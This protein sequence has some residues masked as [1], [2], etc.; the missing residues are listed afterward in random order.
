MG[1]MGFLSCI[2]LMLSGD[3]LFTVNSF[4]A[5][6]GKELKRGSKFLFCSFQYMDGWERAQ[7]GSRLRRPERR[8]QGNTSQKQITADCS[9]GATVPYPF[10]IPSLSTFQ[11]VGVSFVKTKQT[12]A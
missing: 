7:E 10:S 1:K 5:V 2:F 6:K 8:G 12:K 9:T 4:Q 11:N 3:H